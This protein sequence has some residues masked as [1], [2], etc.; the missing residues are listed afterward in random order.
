MSHGFVRQSKR[1]LSNFYLGISGRCQTE[2]RRDGTCLQKNNTKLIHIVVLAHFYTICFYNRHS[3]VIHQL[4]M[5]Q[6][7]ITCSA[8]HAQMEKLAPNYSN[9]H[10][11]KLFSSSPRPKT[12]PNSGKVSEPPPCPCCR[13]P[14]CIRNPNF[15]GSQSQTFDFGGRPKVHLLGFSLRTYL[16]SVLYQKTYSS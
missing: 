5:L 15:H 12:V 8:L 9:A 4:E 7:N 3:W 14:L 13:A 11:F 1:A 16:H 10:L 6:Q 2:T